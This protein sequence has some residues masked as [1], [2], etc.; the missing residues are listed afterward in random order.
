MRADMNRDKNKQTKHTCTAPAPTHLLIVHIRERCRALVR[1]IV[2]HFLWSK[3]CVHLQKQLSKKN[4]SNLCLKN[5]VFFIM[6][7]F[8]HIVT[9]IWVV[10]QSATVT[11]PKILIQMEKEHFYLRE[12]YHIKKILCQPSLGKLQR[13]TIVLANLWSLKKTTNISKQTTALKIRSTIWQMHLQAFICT[14]CVSK[15]AYWIVRT[16]FLCIFTY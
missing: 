3:Y 2:M 15:G 8:W 7:S 11:S 14:A 13:L 12:I 6:F 10:D 5:I 16:P 9:H 1:T 4:A